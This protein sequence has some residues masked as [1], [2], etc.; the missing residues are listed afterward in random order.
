MATV[1][2]D[3]VVVIVLVVVDVVVEVVV[4]V[5]VVVVVAVV[6]VS[7]MSGASGSFIVFLPRPLQSNACPSFDSTANTPKIKLILSE[8]C[9]LPN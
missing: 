4:V 8:I 7:D 6:V 5:V 3:V 1:E 9:I 2:V